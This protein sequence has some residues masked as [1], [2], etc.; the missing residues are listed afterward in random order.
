MDV[1]DVR[2]I[3]MITKLGLFDWVMMPFGMKNVN[4]KI[5]SDDDKS[6]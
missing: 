6:I 3:V 5:F 2:K 4:N 1:E